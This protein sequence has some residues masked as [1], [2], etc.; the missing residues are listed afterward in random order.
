MK[1]FKIFSLTLCFILALTM[2]TGCYYDPPE[3]YT[4]RHRTYREAV[5]YAK[6]IDPNAAVFEG[7]ENIKHEYGHKFR[8]WDAVIRK[9]I[10]KFTA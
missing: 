3:G 10:F 1:K 4:R 8:E 7:Y 5:E 9:Q 6:S 2:L